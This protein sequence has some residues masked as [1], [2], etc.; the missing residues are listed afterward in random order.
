MI[1]SNE[2]LD[3]HVMPII[4]SLTT[5]DG[6]WRMSNDEHTQY[7]ER[8]EALEKAGYLSKKSWEWL[9]DTCTQWNITAAGKDRLNEY[10]ARANEA[11]RRAFEKVQSMK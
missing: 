1:E 6:Y 8:I 10:R 3:G 5:A 11:A 7:D 9:G 4:S 2:F